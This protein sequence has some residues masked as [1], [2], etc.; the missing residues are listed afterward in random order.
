[1]EAGGDDEEDSP[2]SYPARSPS[3]SPDRLPAGMMWSSMGWEPDPSAPGAG[4]D[5]GGDCV[6]AEGNPGGCHHPPGDDYWCPNCASDG[7]QDDDDGEDDVGMD[8][9][10]A[11]SFSPP[12]Q[13][14]A[15]Q[16]ENVELEAIPDSAAFT[17]ED[18]ISFDEEL[19]H[20]ELK[21]ETSP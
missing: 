19:F 18:S 11:S 5:D 3:E 1:V 2:N 7:T 14:A 10:L 9:F 16:L 6:D 15:E 8:A 12:V 20:R 13:P 4:D 21:R 17:V